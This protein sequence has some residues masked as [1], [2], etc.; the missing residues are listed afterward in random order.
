MEAGTVETRMR[1]DAKHESAGRHSR[2]RI[3]PFSG[4]QELRISAN[5]D[6]RLHA[7]AQFRAGD[8]AR[9]PETAHPEIRIGGSASQ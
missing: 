9:L 2:W 5:P 7:V 1:L 6:T 8:F 3:E 4:C